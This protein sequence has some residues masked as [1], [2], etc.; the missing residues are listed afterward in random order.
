M[1]RAERRSKER[2]ERLDY[3]KNTIRMTPQQITKL[4]DD[5]REEVTGFVVEALLTTF[6]LSLHEEF[7]FGYTRI[8]RALQSTDNMYADILNESVY[9]DDL[10]EQLK[11]KTGVVINCGK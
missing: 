6:A 4:K 3:N 1:G 9:L 5:V 11:D 10:K 7:G 8:M 2:V